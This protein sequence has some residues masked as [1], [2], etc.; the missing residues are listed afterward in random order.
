MVIFHLEQ[1]IH[2]DNSSRKAQ[3]IAVQPHLTYVLSL[4]YEGHLENYKH[5]RTVEQP[6]ETDIRVMS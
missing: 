3:R 6:R 4:M 2:V 1:V 5:L